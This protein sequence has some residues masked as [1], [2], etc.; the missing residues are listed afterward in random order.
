M[1]ATL[2]FTRECI[3]WKK[4][5]AISAVTESLALS[6]DCSGLRPQSGILNATG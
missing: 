2:P 1:I 6:S 3:M 5:T 4:E